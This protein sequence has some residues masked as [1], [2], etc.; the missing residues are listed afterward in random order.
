MKQMLKTIAIPGL[1]LAALLAA[2]AAGFVAPAQAACAPGDRIDDTTADWA[3]EKA[4]AAGYSGV[5][6]ERKG[7]DNFWHGVASKDGQTG[8]IV[9]S[10]AGEVTPEGD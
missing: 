6:M 10:P 7:C 9:V 2:P 4:A 1:A 3:M 5:T 8:R